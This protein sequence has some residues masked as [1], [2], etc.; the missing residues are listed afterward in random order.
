M[1]RTLRSEN[2]VCPW[3]KREE[4]LLVCFKY[5]LKMSTPVLTKVSLDR[6]DLISQ[7]SSIVFGKFLA[8]TYS[9]THIKI[10]AN[11]HGTRR[12]LYLLQ[13]LLLYNGS[14]VL[15]VLK[16]NSSGWRVDR[17]AHL[18]QKVMQEGTFTPTMLM[19]YSTDVMQAFNVARLFPD[20]FHSWLSTPK[21]KPRGL[22]NHLFRRYLLEHFNRTGGLDQL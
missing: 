14:T 5:F 22:E 15:E 18:L 3:R 13:A 8:N 7:R 11:Y 21:L 19:L 20:V 4:I 10:T 16:I 9:V 17:I 2:L 1:K 12:C 6:M